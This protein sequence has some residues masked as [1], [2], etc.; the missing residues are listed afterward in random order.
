M[1]TVTNQLLTEW[2][3]NNNDLLTRCVVNQGLD[4]QRHVYCVTTDKEVIKNTNT[5]CYAQLYNKN[6]E[7]SK[8]EWVTTFIYKRNKLT[9]EVVTL[10]TEKL[11]EIFELEWYI[12]DHNEKYFSFS[13]KFGNDCN[14]GILRFVLDI[15]RIMWETNSITDDMYEKILELKELEPYEFL[16]KFYKTIKDLEFHTAHGISYNVVFKEAIDTQH[17]INVVRKY[18]TTNSENLFLSHH[19]NNTKKEWKK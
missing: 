1:P 19:F 10:M 4:H 2:I 13:I 16:E 18:P 17:I 12:T 7:Y 5:S 3:N 6:L 14:N 9:Q 15:I 8:M 11:C